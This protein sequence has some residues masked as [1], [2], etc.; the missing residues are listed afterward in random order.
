MSRAT[1]EEAEQTRQ[2]IMNTALR[3]FARQG[4][5]GT[6]LDDVAS[7]LGVTRGAIYGH[8]Q[9]K[10][11]LFLSVIKLSQDPIYRLI[12]SAQTQ[13]GDQ[14]IA[15][16]RAFIHGWFDLLLDNAAHRDSFELLLNKTELN[17]E[18]EVLYQREKQLTRD[19]IDGIKTVIDAA[20][21]C[22]ELPA[23]SDT[24]FAALMVYTQLMGITQSWLFNPR[25]FSLRRLVDPMTELI[26]TAVEAG[27]T[28]E[29]PTATRPRTVG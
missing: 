15:A 5:G 2:A 19:T 7:E 29:A 18:L 26:I 23:S 28:L 3:V 12:E 13:A 8:F 24:G 4:F 9:S 10:R 20:V 14:P 1:R 17:D 27:T 16:L 21:Q 22:G 11:D 25:L 6:R